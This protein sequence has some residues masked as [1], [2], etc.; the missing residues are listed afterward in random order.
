VSK[1]QSETTIISTQLPTD[2][3]AWL[4]LHVA[5]LRVEVL[6]SGNDEV[7]VPTRSSYIRNLLIKAKNNGSK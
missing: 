4:D 3:V 6:K 7:P 5:Q 1:S 2:L